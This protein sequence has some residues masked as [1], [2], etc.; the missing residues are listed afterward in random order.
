MKKI[1]F[2]LIAMLAVSNTAFADQLTVD[3][4]VYLSNSGV[5]DFVVFF[6]QD[7]TSEVNG[8]QFNILLPETVEFVTEDGK[9]VYKLGTTFPSSGSLDVNIVDGVLKVVMG[10]SD[11]IKGKTGALIAFKI[12]PSSSF[13]TAVGKEISGGKIYEAKE[14]K[15]QISVPFSENPFNIIVTDRVV[16]DENSPFTPTTTGDDINVLVKRTLKAN[17]WSTLFLPFTLSDL[18]LLTTALNDNTAKLAKFTGWSSEDPTYS[19]NIEFST[20]TDFLLANTPYLIYVSSEI[21]EFTFDNVSF[22]D[23][24]APELGAVSKNPIEISN[25]N[26][27]SGS[28]LNKK[29]AKGTMTGTLNLHAMSANEMFLQD[30]KFF[31]GRDG[32]NIKGFR[33]TFTF[34]DPSGNIYLLPNPNGAET[35]ALFSIDGVSGNTTGINSNS[36]VVAKTG[37][38][39]SMTGTYMGEMEDMNRLPKGVYIVDGKKVVKK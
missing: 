37:K 23:V 30:N 18:T 4:K 34:K 2:S 7:K 33:A 32:Q 1:L 5:T 25:M 20:V 36:F 3:E 31:Y 6:N 11:H 13:N 35:R 24:N 28:G 22:G 15:D 29:Y 21:K 14:T 26:I 10:S 19:I 39:Y 27:F 9:P 16:L 8:V 12:Q 38:V 17:T